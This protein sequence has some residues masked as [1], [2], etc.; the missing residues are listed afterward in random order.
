MQYCFQVVIPGCEN[1]ALSDDFN[2]INTF[3]V[4]FDCAFDVDLS[5]DQ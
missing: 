1:I 4:V 5:V 2:P 3:P